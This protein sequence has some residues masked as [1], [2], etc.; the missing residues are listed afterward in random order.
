MNPSNA[1]LVTVD[2]GDTV[3]I[4]IHFDDDIIEIEPGPFTH[5]L[6]DDVRTDDD[7]HLLYTPTKLEDQQICGSM[8]IPL[9]SKKTPESQPN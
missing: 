5:W 9:N 4:G 7:G 3:S 1:T 6:G 2:K 8:P